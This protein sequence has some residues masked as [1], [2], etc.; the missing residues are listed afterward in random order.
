MVFYVDIW[1][2]ALNKFGSYTLVLQTANK[3]A[4]GDPHDEGYD[5]DD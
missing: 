4:N 3:Y 1:I 2:V 5:Y